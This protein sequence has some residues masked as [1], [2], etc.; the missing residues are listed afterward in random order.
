MFALL[1]GFSWYICHCLPDFRVG[2]APLLRMYRPVVGC[3][4]Y[5]HLRFLRGLRPWAPHCPSPVKPHWQPAHADPPMAPP[6]HLLAAAPHEVPYYASRG[7]PKYLPS[8]V[9]FVRCA[10]RRHLPHL[11]HLCGCRASSVML[12]LEG[13]RLQ[14]SASHNFICLSLTNIRTYS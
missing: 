4:G 2:G 8:W 6:H 7:D 14:D 10:R 9:Y 13:S 11:T 3:D 1:C 5:K 12:R